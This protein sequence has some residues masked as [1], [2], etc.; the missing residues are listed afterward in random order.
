MKKSK[1]AIGV[2]AVLGAAWVGGAWFTGQTAETEY[3]RQIELANQQFQALG[4]SDSFN[5][6]YKTKQFERGLFSSQVED[7]VVITLPKENKTWTIPF[8]SKLY[9][10]P[11]P[12]NQLAKFNLMPAMFSIEGFV[13][14]NET[15]QLLF[16]AV[17]SDKP[18]QYHAST[19]Y[20]LSTKG[21]FTLAGGE[22][23]DPKDSKTK[24]TWSNLDIDFD[25]NKDLSGT[26]KTSVDDVV[27]D[28]ANNDINRESVLESSRMQWKGLKS[29]VTYAPTKWAYIY[30]SK[31][32]SSVDSMVMTSLDKNGE[33]HS[34]TEKNI[35]GT[36]ELGLNGDFLNLKATNSMDSLSL[37]DKDIGKIVHNFELNHIEANAANALIESFVKIFNEAKGDQENI[38]LVVKQLLDAWLEQHGMTIFNNQPQ[39][40][41]NPISISDNTGKLALD[42]NIALAQNP[43]FDLM[44]GNLYKQFTDFAVDVQVDKATVENILTKFAPEEEK[45]NIKAKIEELAAQAASNGFAVNGEK[46][47]T[48]KLLLENGELKLNGQAVPEDQVQGII[49]MLLMGAA[50]QR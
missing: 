19:S 1:I 32:S 11:L 18:L 37:D 41:F 12:L 17:K 40:K 23:A 49:F 9:H 50:M 46:S 25:V 4:L 26:Y 20:G 5:V 35:K 10:G 15:T 13:S 45:A 44:R 34:F 8:S 7:E 47:V 27:I 38:D 39:I 22:V 42:L 3:K 29:D 14:K 28:L 2:I 48:M 6:E 36:F 16:D 24:V 43:K 21:G 30:T 31:G 33:T